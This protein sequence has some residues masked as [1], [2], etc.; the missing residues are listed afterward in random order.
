MV[1]LL[2]CTLD[3]AEKCVFAYL[4]CD[5][6]DIHPHQPHCNIPSYHHMGQLR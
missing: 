1:R 5:L 6:P 2:L 4:Y 3:V